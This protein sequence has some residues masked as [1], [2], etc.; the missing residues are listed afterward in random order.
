MIFIILQETQKRSNQ[1][2][3][4]WKIISFRG[5]L[6]QKMQNFNKEEEEEK[7][8]YCSLILRSSFAER[9][10]KV[11][12]WEGWEG[13]DKCDR[14]DKWKK[15]EGCEGWEEWGWLVNK[16]A[17]WKVLFY[18]S[19][20]LSVLINSFITRWLLTSP[21]PPSKGEMRRAIIHEK[22]FGQLFSIIM[23]KLY[24]R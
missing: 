22:L 13:W 24:N 14:W 18:L 20:S 5:F 4:Y 11:C 8:G 15:W 9:S 19:K 3:F 1:K 7:V 12:V 6:L 10:L 17:I 2:V 16:K 21:L 23:R